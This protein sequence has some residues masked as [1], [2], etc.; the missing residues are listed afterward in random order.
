M[1]LQPLCDLLRV[2]ESALASL[3]PSLIERAITSLDLPLHDQAAIALLLQQNSTDASS[4][5]SGY[6]ARQEQRSREPW[7]V[8]LDRALD[9]ASRASTRSDDEITLA[10]TDAAKS[11]LLTPDLAIAACYSVCGNTTS[12]KFFAAIMCL[13]AKQRVQLHNFYV[14]HATG[15]DFVDAVGA[16]LME[17]EVPLFPP[18][19]ALRSLNLRLI[20]EASTP[21]SGGA[22]SERRARQQPSVFLPT[23]PARRLTL[24]DSSSTRQR[25]K[26]LSPSFFNDCRN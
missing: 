8:M 10:F 1:S 15:P 5:L 24:A 25:W 12:Q 17:L 11:A 14:A 2:P 13:P 7:R 19:P 23:D 9:V 16:Q 22:P 3:P 21:P 4:T 18:L 26:Q 6:F 20:A